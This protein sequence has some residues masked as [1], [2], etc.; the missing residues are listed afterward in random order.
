MNFSIISSINDDK[1]K[2]TINENSFVQGTHINDKNVIRQFLSL[3]NIKNE[4]KG[5][6]GNQSNDVKEKYSYFKTVLKD[7]MNEHMSCDK[8]FTTN[9]FK[10][11][12]NCDSVLRAISPRHK[13]LKQSIFDVFENKSFL[14][15][16][17]PTCKFLCELL[18]SN[19]C[20]IIN[21]SQYITITS[22][23]SEI[24]KYL[25]IYESDSDNKSHKYLISNRD[26]NLSDLNN[27]I[28]QYGY[29]Q[30]YSDKDLKRLKLNDIKDVLNERKIIFNP[31]D[32]KNTL[33]QHLLSK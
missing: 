10:Q 11:L 27:M 33:L 19:I 18:H 32:S 28:K 2:F 4:K 8:E 12:D 25:I 15:S 16:N 5:K 29:C 9:F 23:S 14:S 3:D 21:K 26:V 31:K 20:L 6:N 30:F 17:I 13:Q 1:I 22:S 7:V 24:T